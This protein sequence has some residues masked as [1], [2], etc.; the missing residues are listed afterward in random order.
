MEN[1]SGSEE[2]S[3]L[4]LAHAC[5]KN[6]E[7]QSVARTHY[8]GRNV[9]VGVGKTKFE[10]MHDWQREIHKSLKPMFDAAYLPGRKASG[11]L[12]TE[13]DLAVA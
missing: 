7:A 8:I 11:Q 9:N 4:L 10:W 6:G 12:I 3:Q 1:I 2:Y 13:P 5:K